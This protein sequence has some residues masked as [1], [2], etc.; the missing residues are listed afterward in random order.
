VNLYLDGKL[1]IDEL[2][3]RRY[4]LDE[5]EQAHR[6]LAAGTLARGLLVF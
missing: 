2:V 3:T 4:H 6:D 5:V 1:K